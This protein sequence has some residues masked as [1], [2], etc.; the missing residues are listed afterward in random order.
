MLWLTQMGQKGADVVIEGRCTSLTSLS[1]FV[2][3]LARS[4]W[5]KKPVEITDSQ[6]ETVQAAGTD[7]IRFSV[8]AQFAPPGGA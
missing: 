7:V 8:K 1:D 3:N 2:D 5:F 6:V 4:G